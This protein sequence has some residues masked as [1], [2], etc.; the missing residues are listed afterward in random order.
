MPVLALY[1]RVVAKC[2]EALLESKC[3]GFL[4]S[5]APMQGHGARSLGMVK[6]NTG[7]LVIIFYAKVFR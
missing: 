3:W 2:N 4:K 7:S 1:M 5:H 6:E